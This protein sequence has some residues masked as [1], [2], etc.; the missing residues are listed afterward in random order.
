MAVFLFSLV[1]GGGP[2]GRGAGGGNA[3]AL[4]R[5]QAADLAKP[6]PGAARLPAANAE[7]N[8]HPP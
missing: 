1:A 6:S 7:R 4:L 3:Q 2:V 8:A 5:A